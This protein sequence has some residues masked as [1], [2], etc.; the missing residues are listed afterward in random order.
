MRKELD[1]R[2][3]GDRFFH[4]FCY[5]GLT[6]ENKS[7]RDGYGSLIIIY[8]VIIYKAWLLT[9]AAARGSRK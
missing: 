6:T 3:P 7:S 8:K 2:L 5:T 1:G 9:I 4:A